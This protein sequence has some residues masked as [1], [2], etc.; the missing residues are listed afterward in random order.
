MI[1]IRIMILIL[2][3]LRMVSKKR[4]KKYVRFPLLSIAVGITTHAVLHS[5]ALIRRHVFIWLKKK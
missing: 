3:M 1:M 5:K 2:I 4:Y